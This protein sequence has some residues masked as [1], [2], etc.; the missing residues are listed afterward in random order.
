MLS[1]FTASI[2]NFQREHS[3]LM[4]TVLKTN[5]ERYR[6][7]CDISLDKAR[8]LLASF[9]EEKPTS[10][11]FLSD[12]C[13]NSNYKVC[14]PN[15]ESL[16]L[17]IYTR[18]KS[19]FRK[20]RD[21]YQRLGSDLPLPRFIFADESTSLIP[22]PFALHSFVDGILMR[23]IIAQ[24]DHEAI[25]QCCYEAGVMIGKL[26][27]FS[28]VHAGFFGENLHVQPFK[29]TDA[30]R[31]LFASLLKTSNIK[32]ELGFEGVKKIR[33]LIENSSDLLPSNSDGTLCHGD[34]DPSNI[35]VQLTPEGY[36]ISGLLDW[37]F[38]FCGSS[39][40][41][42]GQ[43]LR[44]S[45][46]L[47][48]CYESSLVEGLNKKDFARETWWLKKAKLLDLANLLQ[49]L[50]ANP[51]YRRPIIGSDV[52]ELIWHTINNWHRF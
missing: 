48:P 1:M 23:D 47:H 38:S 30:Y 15:R 36:K 18:D 6:P 8:E 28:F 29:K 10:I 44:Y 39:Y 5:W 14:F 32:H 52:C 16:V 43:M 33:A 50:D 19:A 34:F 20:E 46:K 9:G 42:I 40:S 21:L 13:A 4:Q 51:R 17:R 2:S 24:G 49:L 12:G 11:E 25:A 3:V 22:Y 27:T 7:P 37:E 31:H 26:S 45:H 35:K 41:D